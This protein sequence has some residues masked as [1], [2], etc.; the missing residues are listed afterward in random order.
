MPDQPRPSSVTVIAVVAIVFGALG[1]LCTPLALLPYLG[2]GG[3]NPMLELVRAHP[4][5]HA[6]MLGSTLLNLLLSLLLIAGGIGALSLRAWARLALMAYAVMTLVQSLVGLLVTALALAPLASRSGDDPAA[7]G[8]LAGGLVG[9][10][11]GLCFNG[12]V[13]GLILFVM[14]RPEVRVAFGE[15]S[16]L[17][18]PPAEGS[19]FGLPQ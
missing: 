6:W 10:F 4:L 8:A 18:P 2:V 5:L 11:V 7:L 17:A 16:R 15:E 3:A 19:G 9:G 13:C 14:T 12:V 1:V